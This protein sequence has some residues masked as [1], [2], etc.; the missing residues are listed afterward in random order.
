MTIPLLIA[1]GLAAILNWL[2]VAA[3]VRWLELVS[4]P[5]VPIFLVGL[6][7]SMEANPRRANWFVV[8]LLFSLA[9][10]V[11]LMLR[12]NLFIAGLVAF[13]LAHVAFIVGL[14]PDADP[15]LIAVAAVA[16]GVVVVPLLRRV[17]KGAA[18]VAPG[19]VPPVYAYGVVITAMAAVAMGTANPF[20]MAGGLMFLLSD[21]LLAW[22]R[23]VRP[24]GWGPLFVMVTYHAALFGLVMSL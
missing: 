1:A 21:A 7:L 13:L 20:A 24:F 5:A 22:N 4:K 19:L 11:F 2:A 10:D 6:V 15:T 18:Q 23:F 14:A 3:R 17:A 16:M 9:G 8:A 12:A